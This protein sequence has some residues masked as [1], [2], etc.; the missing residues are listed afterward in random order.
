M[1]LAFFIGRLIFGLYWLSVAKGHL[2]QPAGLI[3]YAQSKGVK[4]GKL[5]VMGTGVL[6]L[7]GGLSIIL[8]VKPHYGIALLVIFL[9]GVSFKMHAYWK[10]TDP[11]AKMGDH[12]NFTKN[13]A[14]VG[15]LLIMYG[16]SAA[17]W[18]YPFAW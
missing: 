9:I 12:I 10:E 15:A 4:S 17:M 11:A 14:L 2:L 18:G 7:L 5:A 3:G 6:A 1:A 8:G 16:V 13:M